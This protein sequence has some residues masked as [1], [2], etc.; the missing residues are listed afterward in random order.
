MPVAVVKSE[1]AA[2]AEQIKAGK[3]VVEIIDS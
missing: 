1:V 3:F 2:L